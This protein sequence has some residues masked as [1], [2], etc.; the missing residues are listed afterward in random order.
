MKASPL[1]SVKNAHLLRYTNKIE[2]Q[3]LGNK[4]KGLDFELY[5]G[6]HIAIVGS[7]GSGKSTLLRLL[8]G[9]AWLN[10]G[11]ILWKDN[12]ISSE[13]AVYD[14]TPIVGKRM[15]ALVSFAEQEKYIRQAWNITAD[16]L[17]ATGFDNVLLLYNDLSEEQKSRIEELAKEL[18][19][20]HLLD[21][22]VN[23][24]SQGQLRILLLAR[25]LISS[26]QVLLLDEYTE[27]LD[28]DY[29]RQ[30]LS[31]LE[32]IS[33]KTT[34][35]LTSHRP[36]TL[37]SWVQKTFYLK[38][39][40]LSLDLPLA[41]SIEQAQ[42]TE[43]KRLAISEK[44]KG[45]A[46]D[47]EKALATLPPLI[48]IKNACVFLDHAEIL[49]NLNWTWKQNEHWLIYGKNGSGKSTFLKL[50]ASEE[51]P[52][53][54]GSIQRNLGDAEHILT[55]VKKK[56]ALISDKLQASY[57]Y[58][59]TAQELLL[60]GIDNTIGIYRTFTEEE[61]ERANYWLKFVKM[62]AFA[63]RSIF[64]LSTGQARRL[65]LARAL[66]TQPKILLLD[67]PYTGLD[68][69]SRLEFM[70][71]LEKSIEEGM[72][73]LIVSHH[74]EDVYFCNRTACIDKGYLKIEA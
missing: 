68:H 30:V 26:P 16:Y 10:K 29:R 32:K 5:K 20:T 12:G 62:E 36:E 61:H 34:L 52:A 13:K 49:H 63:H 42:I 64:T 53:L 11:E 27:G 31:S 18:D 67:E 23:K 6:E 19:I 22:N 65:Y 54:G 17:I 33:E 2:H 25:A 4:T 66:M 70:Q 56:I 40:L 1:I 38:H 69:A 46:K 35:L 3:V 15:C 50:L 7:N 37:P 24:L 55:Q 41:Y 59:V 9:D 21:K 8:R 72:H 44:N 14:N 73:L 28:V 57:A 43:Q 60:S 45:N 51:Y 39:G 48:E 74:K 47:N 58:E 71:I